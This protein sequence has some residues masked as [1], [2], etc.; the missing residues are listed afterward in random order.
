MVTLH[1]RMLHRSSNELILNCVQSKHHNR[2]KKPT[3]RVINPIDPASQ[4]RSG[5]GQSGGIAGTE[6]NDN[7][8]RRTGLPPKHNQAARGGPSMSPDVNASEIMQNMVMNDDDKE[9][10]AQL[11]KKQA[12]TFLKPRNTVTHGFDVGLNCGIDHEGRQIFESECLFCVAETCTMAAGGIHG[13]VAP[14]KIRKKRRKR[15]S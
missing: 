10:Y 12:K 11:F 14:Y 4:P 15:K 1:L 9:W 8:D 5:R 7:P 13:F 6:W 2:P 3:N